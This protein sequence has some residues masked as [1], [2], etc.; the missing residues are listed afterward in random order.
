VFLYE[1]K[2]R[3]LEYDISYLI[4]FGL[5]NSQFMG[6]ACNAS[7]GEVEIERSLGLIGQ[8]ILFIFIP[9]F[10]VKDPVATLKVDDY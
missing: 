2:H 6:H 9:Q 5:L 10:P 4:K 3:C 8:P 7:T 1:N